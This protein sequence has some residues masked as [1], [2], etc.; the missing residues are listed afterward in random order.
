[1]AAGVSRCPR[2]EDGMNREQQ[3]QKSR[4]WRLQQ[5]ERGALPQVRT[6][7]RTGTRTGKREENR[8]E[9]TDNLLEGGQDIGSLDTDLIDRLLSGSTPVKKTGSTL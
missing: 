8:E 5:K 4:T 6:G 7:T 2:D 1:M 9:D 3:R